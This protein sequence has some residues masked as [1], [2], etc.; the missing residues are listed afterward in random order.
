M[1]YTLN[2]HV[3]NF[4]II[5]GI[6]Q[7]L[8]V[9]AILFFKKSE[10]KLSNRL[11][12]GIIFTVSMHLANLMILDTN[13]DNHYPELLW[14]PYSYLLGIGPLIYCYTLSLVE[15]GFSMRGVSFKHFIPVLCEVVFQVLQSTYS[16]WEDV[17]YYAVPTD[18][19]FSA[20]TYVVGF[21]SILYYIDRSLDS[22]RERENWL[23]KYYSNLKGITLRWL[24]NSI[25]H[26]RILWALWVPFA[27]LFLLFFRFQLQY[28]GLVIIIYA[29]MIAITS[30]TYW[31]GIEGFRQLEIIKLRTG[32][33]GKSTSYE[34]MAQADIQNHVDRMNELMQI[35][36][37][38]LI[39]NLELRDLARELSQNPNL[40]SHI[41]NTHFGVNFHEYVNRFRVEEVKTRITDPAFKHLTILGIALESGFNSKTSFNRVFKQMTGM[42][43][44]QF[45]RERKNKI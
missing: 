11:L 27:V 31:M 18:F 28:L 33:D 20:T 30:L 24:Y 38:Y 41:L 44:T 6:I 17:I 4:L 40:V 13:L 39:E 26:Y 8:I 16:V 1:T 22:I 5:S 10:R 12:A 34:R 2:L 14:I 29:L 23:L 35:R 7:C 15:P 42:T 25:R 37:L 19:F 36:K 32:V 43:P 9:S 21:A 3:V 45:Q